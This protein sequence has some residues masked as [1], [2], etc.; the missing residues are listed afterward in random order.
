MA[1]PVQEPKE[2]QKWKHN[3][4]SLYNIS[5]VEKQTHTSQ[6][7]WLLMFVLLK[8]QVTFVLASHPYGRIHLNSSEK[9]SVLGTEG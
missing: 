4:D 1:K 2:Q 5:F 3:E 8:Y 9:E 6:N 7:T